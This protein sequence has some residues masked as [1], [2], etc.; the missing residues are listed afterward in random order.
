M[1]IRL[2]LAAA[3]AALGIGLAAAEPAVSIG[4]TSAAKSCS[5]S[6]YTHAALSWGHKC[7]ATG[8]FC[9]ASAD[10]E[11]HRYRFHCHKRDVNGSY[12]L[13]R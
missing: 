11:Y 10:R 13:T 8:Q 1:R 6:R 7:L 3:V 12:H 4:P 5:G 9:K 2:A